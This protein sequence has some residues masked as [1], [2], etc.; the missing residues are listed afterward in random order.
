[1]LSLKL[2]FHAKSGRLNPVMDIGFLR[3]NPVITERQLVK[4]MMQGTL[5]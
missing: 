4:G 1:L 2:I 3:N 5:A